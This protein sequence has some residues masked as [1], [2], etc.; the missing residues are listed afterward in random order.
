MRR[1]IYLLLTV[2]LAL[3]AF[4]AKV[5]A[6]DNIKVGIIQLLENDDF[7]AMREGFLQ[8]LKAKGFNAQTEFF[9]A[10]IMKY[11]DT[12]VQRGRD[13]AKKMVAEGVDIMF[14]PGM[15]L[16]LGDSTGNVPLFD[17]TLYITDATMGAFVKKGDKV[18]SKSNATGVYL[19]YSFR[20]IVKF[21]KEAIPKAKTIAYIHN[22]KSPVD[23][24]VDE[25]RAEADKAG[26]KVVSYAFGTKEEALAALAKA[27]PKTEVAFATND[28]FVSN[29]H[30]QSIQFGIKNRYPVLFAIA[31]LANSGALF[32]IQYSMRRAGEITGN[33]A[34]EVLTKKV[35]ANSIPCETSDKY[36]IGVNIKTAET[37]GIQIPYTWIELSTNVVK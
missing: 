7:V 37:L 3:T 17:A 20:D 5:Y 10:D 9:N 8:A 31:P 25:F 26:L 11:P 4:S 30:A 14:V 32:A 6:G 21:I 18:Y 15:H 19:T 33:K 1:I 16:H 36:D 35:A 23:R 29:A 28:I 2:T 24:P 27:K 22:P 13:A 34:V 12:F